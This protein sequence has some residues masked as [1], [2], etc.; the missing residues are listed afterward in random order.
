VA[1]RTSS[2]PE[3]AGDAAELVDPTNPA[4]MAGAVISILKSPAR[5]MDLVAKGLARASLYSWEKTAARLL[6]IFEEVGG[7]GAH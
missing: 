4:E 5:R 6:S 2:I 7:R 1:S 3:V